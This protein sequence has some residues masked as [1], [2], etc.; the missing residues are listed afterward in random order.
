MSKMATADCS[1]TQQFGIGTTG[2]G[3]FQLDAKELNDLSITARKIKNKKNPDGTKSG[4]A[5]TVYDVTLKY[6]DADGA[7]QSYGKRGFLSKHEALEHEAE[8]RKKMTLGFFEP[9]RAADTKQTV[10]QY[11]DSWLEMHGKA[12]L[13]PST[14]AGYKSHMNNHILPYIGN[15]QLN[16]LTPKAID[17]MLAKLNE[18]KLSQSTLRYAQRI[19]SV[20]MEA[21][22]KYGY[23]EGNPAR[24]ILT[25]I[26]KDAKTPDPYTVEQMQGLMSKC[27]GTE[28][29]MLIVL[30]GMYGL[31]RN[32]V[33]GLRWSN[34]DLDRKTLSIIEQL[35]FGVPANT[36][37]INEMAPPKSSG[38]EL[39]I[40][41]AT[42]HYFINHFQK[43]QKQ[44]ELSD[45]SG[46][47]YYDNNL[48]VSKAD[49][50]PLRGE[51][52][53]ANWG[54]L[55]RHLKMPHMRFHDLR[56]TAATNMH[57]LTGD[58]YTVGQ[59]L[60][61]SLKGIGLSL[62]I[63]TNMADVTARYVDVRN[64][65]KLVV[66]DAYHNALHPK[67]LQKAESKK[68]ATRERDER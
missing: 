13:R 4:K 52:I 22:R 39:P 8:V 17:E 63:S 15:I 41:D 5:G 1:L 11:L 56:H 53:S 49:G 7:Y 23:I 3:F 6:K 60:G 10:K 64:S 20:A 18:R 38:R 31:R 9:T 26:G 2:I 36:T 65:R 42:L 27:I 40:T 58:F 19:L 51:R 48:V 66:L 68:R 14:Y 33:L 55:L 62:G 30:S 32:E 50:A 12:N 67:E 45:L 24:D 34:V 25:K 44:R 59:I 47:P 28:W 46:L 43:Q 37:I 16:K 35:P 29:E 21:A 61:H 57:E 54:Q